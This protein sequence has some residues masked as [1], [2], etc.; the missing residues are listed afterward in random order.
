M[1]AAA[2]D[3]R[4]LQER[5][6][7]I[8]DASARLEG[9]SLADRLSRL[10]PEARQRIYA[11]LTP[12]DWRILQYEWAFWARPK[13]QAPQ[14]DYDVLLWLAGRGFGKSQAGSEWVR[15]R[16]ESGAKSIALIGET[17]GEIRR[18]MV[19]GDEGGNPRPD[20]SGL[21]DVCPPWMGLRWIKGDRELHFRYHNAIA[22]ACS[23]E[24]AELRGPN[25]DTVWGDEIIK[26]RYPD[27]I[28]SNMSLALRGVTATGLRPQ[29]ALT[30]TPRPMRLL[31]AI[32]MDQS[33]VTIRG[34]LMENSALPAMYV[35]RQLRQLGGTRLGLQELYGEVLGD[36]P[37][38]L[39]DQATIDLH[40]REQQPHLTK[41]VVGVD[42]AASKKRK[43]DD[44]GI[45][46]AGLGEDSHVYV[47]E[48]A[49]GRYTPEEWGRRVVTL[50]DDWNASVVVERNRVGDLAAANIRAGYRETHGARA[51]V[52]IEEVLAMGSKEQ[53]AEPISTLYERGRVHHVGRLMR[54]EDEMTEW[55]PKTTVSPNGLDALV[56]AVFVLTDIGEKEDPVNMSG[57]AA[58]QAGFGAQSPWSGGELL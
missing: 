42:P 55:D 30:T 24:K 17:D 51:A 15:Q 19:G 40:R 2:I 39:F 6:A 3:P 41:V 18:W 7:A 22:Y 44:T 11:E 31:K 32:I 5:L 34:R 14:C 47:L 57:F 35:D 54:L 52:P 4:A 37:D 27:A 8:R 26:W 43:S 23:A 36:N 12:L 9:P 20:K 56:H 46:V 21:I 1:A 10:E 33:T 58:A 45:V 50:V 29:V 38:S 16:V 25:L 13:Q 48:D 28:W 49:T 53:R